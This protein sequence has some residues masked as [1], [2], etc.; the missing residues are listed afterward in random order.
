MAWKYTTNNNNNIFIS[1]YCNAGLWALL[2]WNV[3]RESWSFYSTLF[4][5]L[6]FRLHTTHS[7]KVLVVQIKR[8]Q[9]A[10]VDCRNGTSYPSLTWPVTLLSVS[11]QS[12]HWWPWKAS[13]ELFILHYVDNSTETVY[14]HAKFSSTYLFLAVT[15]GIFWISLNQ[16]Q[17]Y[18]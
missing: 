1:V 18:M 15:T 17:T 16:K 5:W 3:L 7:M 11:K 12:R 8:T 9:P 6:H 2:E 10:S 14:L 4:H 13:G